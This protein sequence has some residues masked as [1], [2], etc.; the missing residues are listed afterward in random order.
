M[1]ISFNNIP[2]NI[3]VPLFYAE[4]DNS[5]ASSFSQNKR[6]LLI[7]QKLAA[8]TAEANVPLLVSRTDDAKVQFGLGSML[9]RM[10]EVY[11]KNDSFGEVWC[12]ALDENG[13]GVAASGTVTVTG[14][15]SG[16]GTISLY[17]AGQR[18]QVAVALSSTA[19]ATA[20]AIVAA[21]NAATDLPVT[22]SNAAGVVT[23]TARWKG[24]TGNGITVSDSF[25]GQPG[26]EVLPAGQALAYVA[27]ASGA[28][29]PSLTTAITGMGDEEYDYIVHPFTDATSLND[30]AAE[31]NDTTGRWSWASQVYGHAYTA[32]RGTLSA[33]AA[34]GAAR[35]DQH[36]TIAGFENDVRAPSWEYI[37]AYAARNAVFLNADVARPTQTGELVGILPA[38]PGN[39]FIR[40]E[41]QTLLN[42]G[43]ATSYVGGGVV[44]VERAITTY[45]KNAFNQADPSYLDSE[46][47]HTSAHVIR[48]IRSRVTS[49]YARHKLA[50]DGTRF[51]AGQAIVTP[52]VIRGEMV[53][54]Y[55]D[56]E[57][58]G[59]VENGKLF[60]EHLVVEIDANNPNR[61]NVLF[62]PDLV[63]QLRIFALINQF[64]LNY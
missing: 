60:A 40:T 25:L 59:I 37:A 52:S 57:L 5:A 2:A 28:T 64:R 50:A 30:L 21:V 48:F 62:P 4:M 51:G 46:T 11:R 54:A 16:A 35:N 33:L 61:I 31:L 18:V 23:L 29:N 34:A 63:N 43:I 7:G 27:M 56:M 3:R 1:A 44:R 39:R 47:L 10:H 32:L 53:A 19:T 26:G 38:R 49:K 12:I 36:S 9:A 22:A 6:T 13:A 58:D 45:Q 42:S 55:A 15:S 14:T 20:A 41:R 8:G 17:V 24:A